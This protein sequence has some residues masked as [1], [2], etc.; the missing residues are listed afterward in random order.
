MNVVFTKALEE[1][2]QEVG[3]DELT[4]S[5][6]EQWDFVELGYWLGVYSH[7]VNMAQLVSHYDYRFLDPKERAST[8]YEH[9]DRFVADQCKRQTNRFFV[10]MRRKFESNSPEFKATFGELQTL[11]S[12]RADAYN[13]AVM[14]PF[15]EA[16]L[17]LYELETEDQA[18]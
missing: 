18:E 9:M 13:A 14:C 3:S 5:K 7:T 16:G 2:Q 10:L 8:L 6:N 17:D 1:F 15:D 4:F 12:Y 11:F